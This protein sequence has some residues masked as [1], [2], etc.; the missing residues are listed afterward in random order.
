[1]IPSS[2]AFYGDQTRWFVGRVISIQDPLEMGRVK[3]RIVGIHDSKEIRDGDLPWAQVIIPVTEGGS[4]GL[5]ASTGIKEQAQVFGVF[6]DGVHSQL[7]LVVGSMPKFEADFA[8]IS[9]TYQP[10]IPSHLDP[11]V[12]KNL[13]PAD[14]VDEENLYGDTNIEKATYTPDTTERLPISEDTILVHRKKH[15]NTLYTINAMNIIIKM[16][17]NGVLDKTYQLNWE[18]YKNTILLS[19]DDELNK[20]PT[21]VYKIISL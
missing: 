9:N 7:P 17:N 8:S 15:T 14:Q 3:V 16:N 6:L 10:N 1:M 11:A 2:P 12:N 13:L 20:L 18:L 21:K 19:N 4:S 5:G